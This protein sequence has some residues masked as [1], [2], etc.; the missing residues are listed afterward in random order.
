MD[1]EVTLQVLSLVGGLGTPVFFVIKWILKDRENSTNFD[2]SQIFTKQDWLTERAEL[3]QENRDLRS[4]I[5]SLHA[6]IDQI[7]DQKDQEIEK[8][9]KENFTLHAEVREL[10]HQ[11]KNLEQVNVDNPK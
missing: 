11:V 6:K 7:R 1:T 2:R 3:K 5:A 8:L 10:R 9:Q 4:E